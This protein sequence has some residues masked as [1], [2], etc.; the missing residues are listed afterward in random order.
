MEDA[1]ETVRFNRRLGVDF[2]RINVVLSFPKLE[3][4]EYAIANGYLPKRQTI[5]EFD[6]ELREPAFESPFR[7]EIKNLCCFFHIAVRFPFLMPL[8][9]RLIKLPH[10]WLF[11]QFS[12]YV[13]YQEMRFFRIRFW[14]GLMYFLHVMTSFKC[15]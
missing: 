9:A 10:N 15:G 3:I 12:K 11:A 13:A 5:D 8:I 4:V 7:N 1:F 2:T 14:K 6:Q